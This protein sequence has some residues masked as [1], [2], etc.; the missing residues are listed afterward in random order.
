MWNYP[1][2]VVPALAAKLARA[3]YACLRGHPRS[4]DGK[5]DVD[6]RDKPG[7]DDGVIECNIGKPRAVHELI[8]SVGIPLGLGL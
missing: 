3:A 5:R 4:S 6:G 2:T 7:H 1:S 8:E